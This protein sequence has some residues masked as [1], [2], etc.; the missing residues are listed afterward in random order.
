M[1]T[2]IITKSFLLMVSVV[3]IGLMP[4]ISC[5]DDSAVGARL[6]GK[7]EL[8]EVLDGPREITR[9]GNKK[10][11]PQDSVTVKFQTG[12]VKLSIKNDATK[13]MDYYYPEDQ[14]RYNTNDPVIVIGNAPF[15]YTFED[16]LLK[17]H[18]CGFYLCDHRPATFVFK[19]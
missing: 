11:I 19:K 4:I 9:Y 18:Y 14:E 12:K 1:K 13:T 3:I 8:I 16:G 7:W 17:L 15:G 10:V 6:R 5:T 2:T